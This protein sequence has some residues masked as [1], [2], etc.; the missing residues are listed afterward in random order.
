VILPLQIATRRA[1]GAGEGIEVAGGETLDSAGAEKVTHGGLTRMTRETVKVGD[2]SDALLQRAGED[3]DLRR[4]NVNDGER[5]GGSGTGEDDV[6]FVSDDDEVSSRRKGDG[7]A[8]GGEPAA[9]DKVEGG[10]REVMSVV[11]D[12]LLNSIKSLNIKND[13]SLTDGFKQVRDG[14]GSN[15]GEVGGVS[16]ETAA[17][18]NVVTVA[19]RIRVSG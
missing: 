2:N 12:D 11:K 8:R 18:D 4:D 3:E 13:V 14:R 17:I 9:R 10:R 19:T 15:G 7:K 16:G 5:T 6:V 1:G